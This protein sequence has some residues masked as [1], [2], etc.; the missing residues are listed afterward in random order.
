[1]GVVGM[2]GGEGWGGVVVV[3]GRGKEGDWAGLWKEA[4]EGGGAVRV[5]CG[6]RAGKLVVSGWGGGVGW[7]GR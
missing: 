2:W 5:G 6:K 1:M 7:R 4:V 3:G